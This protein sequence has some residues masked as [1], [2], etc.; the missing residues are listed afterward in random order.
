MP[1][2]IH[3][4]VIVAHL[5]M[6]MTAGMVLA[7]PLEFADL[8]PPVGNN[9]QEPT[10]FALQ[11]DRV[12]LGWTEPHPAGFAVKLSVLE[13]AEWSAARTV[14]VSDE[15]FVNWADFPSV[16]A[17]DD[18][19]FAAHWLWENSKH[20]YAYDV[21][22]SLSPDEGLTW[23]AP[24]TPHD[25]RSVSQ[26]GFVTLQPL[27]DGSLMSVWLDGRAYDKPLF[28]SAASNYPDAMQ[29]R[30]TRITPEGTRTDDVLVDAQ[31]CSCCQTS[32]AS[33]DDGTVLVA[34]RDRTDAEI[35]DISVVRHQGGMWSE[36]TN[37][38]NDGWEI[39]GCPVNGP[40]IATAGQTAAVA[41]F[42]AANDKPEVKVA[43]SS[44]GGRN[45]GD[46]A[47]VSLGIPAGRVD[48]LMLDPQTAFVTW[49]EWANES[50]V[51][52]ACQITT[53]QQCKDLQLIA[54]NNGAGSVNFPRTARTNEGVYLSWTQPSNSDDPEPSSTIRTVF[55][56]Y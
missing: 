12:L 2:K 31:T 56:S 28:T 30:A 35:R 50:E 48:I 53:G 22:I 32:A 26:H 10:L 5:F 24:I 7:E 3:S 54:R 21:K 40:A 25:D 6:G 43:F 27:E 44:D 19:T 51:I 13:D 15:L 42:T 23:S 20:D 18:G 55:A 38:H 46:L 34:Y 29:L 37:V 4:G 45:F 36:P 16:V 52:L 33:L 17:L 47:K 41:W 1:S 11:D 39:S 9:A 49:V 14:T 8:D